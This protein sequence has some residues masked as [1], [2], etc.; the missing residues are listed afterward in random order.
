MNELLRGILRPGRMGAGE[1]RSDLYLLLA[2]TLLL[3][4]TGVGLRD[5]WP[6]DEPRFALIASD[7]MRS[8]EWLIPQVGADIYADKPPL[9][10]WLMALCMT[11][12]Q[13]LRVGF[14]LPS[15]LS[16]IGCVALIYDIS[17][18]LWNRETALVAGLA[19]LL[20]V[21]FVWQARQAQID[22]TLC[23][24][25]TL[26][27]YGLLRHCLAGPAWR[28]YAIGWAAAGLGIITKGVGFLPL[29]ILVPW[30]LTRRPAASIRNGDSPHF[31]GKWGLS[32]FLC[33][34]LGPIALLAAVS[35]WLAPMLLA[36][37]SDPQIAAYRDEILFRQTVH[38]Y[39]DAWHHRQPFW[40]FIVE[41][42]PLL[43]LPLTALLPW[44][45]PH[46][47]EAFRA[48]DLRVALPLIWVVL[49]IAFFSFSSGKRGVYVLPA[50]PALVLAAA[51]ALTRIAAH[52]GAQWMGFWIAMTIT[53]VTLGGALYLLADSAARDELT[54]QV[55]V[56]VI[57]PLLIIGVAGA[58]ACV[59]GRPARGFA[60]YAA[61]LTGAL[62][63]VSFW[64]DP[65]M[66]E[67]RSGAG[68]T[69]KVM[70][71]AAAIAPHSELGF[72]AY[73]EQYLLYSTRPIVNFGHSR[74]REGDQEAFDAA[75]WMAADPTRLLLV[76]DRVRTRCFPSAHARAVAV[77]N[78][79]H[80]SLI[81][82]AANPE[83]VHRG[84]LRA[85][86]TYLRG[87]GLSGAH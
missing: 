16:G 29:L 54:D 21:Q 81:T 47:R 59:I 42:I 50:L 79:K 74:W 45:W 5:P 31:P 2:F 44:L 78:R 40:Y 68:F 15:L 63:V 64:I 84:K 75:V 37:Q 73:T 8:G 4:A 85:A 53:A 30:V 76:D 58:L 60:A 65:L 87:R 51:P 39:A 69:R 10:F 6:A 38:R 55:A 72:V 22:A 80:W 34:L 14:L 46:W 52:R 70:A 48:R 77:A 83:C 25:T 28:W 41:V 1:V 57:G 66:N 62:L 18:R 19:L 17:R 20:S 43:W 11:L 36:A 49:V 9:F 3:I 26:S 56:N 7:M 67:M 27:L 33:W 86:R 12:T 71:A 13:S 82:G 24:W 61:T 35:I 32:P 23:F